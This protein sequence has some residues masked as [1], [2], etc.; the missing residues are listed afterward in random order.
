MLSVRLML[1]QPVLET[2]R[3]LLRAFTLGD[4]PVVQQLAGDRAIADTTLNIPH[5]YE[6]GMAEAWISTHEE[7]REQDLSVTFAI[8]RRADDVL[9]GAVGL[10]VHRAGYRAELGYWIGRP[11]WNHGYGTEAAR[12]VVGFGFG[13]LGLHRI[14]AHHLARNPASGRI[15][16]KIGMTREG[17]L[18]G[19]VRKWDT[20]EDVVVYGMLSDQTTG[21]RDPASAHPPGA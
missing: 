16:Q 14:C 2:P 5:P 11:Y 1:I 8:V 20:F 6:D 10:T 21:T 7:M 9:V 17:T 19:Y 18:R 13:Q 4:A 3:L 12:V 15:M